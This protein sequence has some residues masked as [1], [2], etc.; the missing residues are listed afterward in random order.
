[1]GTP[2]ISLPDDMPKSVRQHEDAALREHL[3]VQ[4]DGAAKAIEHHR[5]EMQRAIR[6]FTAC[7][8]GV[9]AMNEIANTQEQE[10]HP[11]QT[12]EA[13]SA[14]IQREPSTYRN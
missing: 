11:L 2:H 6:V 10:A 7:E 1:M 9:A 8:A 12:L 4:R 3:L 13:E 14:S 5:E